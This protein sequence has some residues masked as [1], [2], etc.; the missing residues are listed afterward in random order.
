MT[1]PVMVMSLQ[2]RTVL[3]SPLETM[4]VAI[5]KM[6]VYRVPVLEVHLLFLKFSQ[7]QFQH[8][9]IFLLKSLLL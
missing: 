1:L 8:V 5:Q 3:M 4:T 9:S 2:L 6:S 7:R